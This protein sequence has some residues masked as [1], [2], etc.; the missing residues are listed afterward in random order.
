[1]KGW[2]FDMNLKR[3]FRIIYMLFKMKLSKSM[4]YRL[5][6]FGVTFVDGTRVIIQL[7]LFTAIYSQVDTIGGWD[8]YQYL[9]FL[10]TI[11]FIDSVVMILTFFGVISIPGNIRSGRLDLYITK[12]INS[13]L[14]QSFESIN[15]GSLPLCLFNIG[16]ITYSA[17]NMN[18]EITAIK[19]I[20]YIFL[21]LLMTLLWYDLLVIIRTIPFF[22]IKAS[23][24][25]KI[26]GEFVDL[27]F[28][29]P[30]VLFKKGL[31]VLFYLIL[32][33]GI[34][35]TI[36]TEF[37]AGT[38]ELNGFLYAVGIVTFFTAFMLWFWRFGL[39]HY[40]SASS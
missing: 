16:L 2:E 9:F 18:I 22:V 15:I 27:C 17:A 10:G 38:L 5:S 36:P 37:F 19:I 8:R 6:F 30:G 35:A 26:E 12:P 4:M 24:L 3:Q 7:L 31:K 23:S 14:Y 11:A 32:P 25:E 29:I 21:I 20:G 13:L 28:R 39:R 40:K 1:M 34:I 33:Y